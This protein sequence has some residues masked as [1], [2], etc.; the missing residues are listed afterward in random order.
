MLPADTKRRGGL[1]PTPVATIVGAYLVSTAYLAVESSPSLFYV[2]N[3]FAHAFGGALLT[4]ALAAWAVRG[5]RQARSAGGPAFAV[6]VISALLIVASAVSAAVLA[7]RHHTRETAWLLDLHIVLAVSGMVGAL[8]ACILHARRAPS[9]AL[10][11]GL[12]VLGAAALLCVGLVLAWPPLVTAPRYE[13]QRIEN[14]PPPFEMAQEAMGGPEGPFFPSSAAT[15]T[16]GRIPSNFFMTSEACARCHQD[17][18]DAW[19]ESAHHFSSFNNQWYRRS[20]EYMQEV[21]SVQ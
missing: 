5:L 16:G 2:A 7:W 19:N 9:P 20:I 14:P 21:N 15:S 10:D 4:V 13:A 11:S 1:A 8:L 6:G 12:R 17:I 18:F 3:V